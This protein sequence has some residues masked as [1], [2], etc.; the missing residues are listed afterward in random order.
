MQAGRQPALVIGSKRKQS[1]D[2]GR[3]RLMVAGAVFA[4]AFLVIGGRL[5]E[6]SVVK[7]GGEPRQ[8]A[9]GGEQSFQIGR[10]DIVD[11]NGIVLA[12]T[13]PTA[14]LFANARQVDNPERVAA[15]LASVLEGVS[16]PRLEKLLAGDRAFVYLKRDLTPREQSEVNALGEP[17]LYFQKESKRVYP[18]GALLSHVV[19]FTDIDNRGLAGME[20]AFDETLR[21]SSEPLELSVDLRVQHILTEELAA[22]MTE[23][24]GIG[25]AGVIMDALTGEVVAMTSLPNFH[26]SD[27]GRADKDARFNRATLG[28]YEMGSVFKLLTAAMALDTGAVELTDS[29]N[30]SKPIKI[31]RFTINDYKPKGPELTVPE[32]MIHS[33]NIG[34]VHMVERVGIETQQRYLGDFGLLEP[35]AIELPEVGAPLVPRPWREISMMTVSYGHGLSVSPLQLV[36]AMSAVVNGG[37]R[38]PATL[39][40]RPG[41]QPVGGERVISPETSEQVSWLMRQVVTKGTGKYADAKGYLVGGKTGTAD[42]LRG[43]RYAEDARIASFIGA[44]PMDNPRYVIFAM[45]DEPKG[46]KRTYGYAT[47]GWVA[48]P[49]VGR[50]VERAA[51][52]LGISRRTYEVAAPAAAGLLLEASA[53][54]ATSH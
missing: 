42:K 27:A 28:T 39:L 18:Q 46:I 34:T 26:P 30:T 24:S 37:L 12:T 10:A 53:D 20:Q 25:A 2:V 49:V 5:I 44:F 35:A 45:V 54:G 48:A 14:S 13:L 36:S 11:R 9:A 32:I 23:F 3:T 31:A 1:L 38:K 7:P 8:A 4:L 19:G 47:G 33:S 29:F 22:A 52:L 43:G 21:G 41:N 6:L 40:K 50:V 15:K 51:P 17:G 16:Q